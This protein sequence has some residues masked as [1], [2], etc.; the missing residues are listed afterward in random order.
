MHCLD[1]PIKPESLAQTFDRVLQIDENSDKILTLGLLVD[2]LGSRG[3]GLLLLILSLPSALPI[4]AP[5]YSTPFGIA[6]VLLAAQLLYQRK[7]IWLPQ[8]LR[9]KSIKIDTAKKIRSIGS[10][11]FNITEHL[12]HPRW[13]WLLNPFNR[14]LLSL[15]IL[16]MGTLMI[17][18]IPLTNSAPA[19][20]VFIISLGLAERDGLIATMGLLLGFLAILLYSSIIVLTLL[21]GPE[22]IDQIKNQFFN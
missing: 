22:I 2:T 21:H 5:G 11:L 9:Q 15:I 4:P 17:M 10:R 6:I 1:K 13:E 7:K 14:N 8:S 18:P 3:V 16:L 12:I 19:M 20:V